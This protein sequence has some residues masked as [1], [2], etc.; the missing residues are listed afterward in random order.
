MT[1]RPN[2]RA[3]RRLPLLAALAVLTIAAGGAAAGWYWNPGPGIAPSF[4]HDIDDEIIV[5]NP[6]YVGP[7][8]CAECHANRVGEFLGTRHA[9]ACVEPSAQR[10]TPSLATQPN[11][12]TVPGANVRFEMSRAGDDFLLTAVR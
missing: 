10:V 12:L 6:G 7:N 11:A 1:D 4:T 3:R 9:I 8:A 2:T 5:T